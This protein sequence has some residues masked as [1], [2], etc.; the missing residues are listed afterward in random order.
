MSLLNLLQWLQSTGLAT[1][2][3]Q[4]ILVFPLVE[5]THILSLSVSV[6]MILVFDL[7]LMQATL[8]N[9]SVSLVMD[10][11]MRWAL[12]CFALTF[13]TGALLF[14]TEAVRAYEN[15]FFRA[16]VALLAMAGLNALFYRVRYVPQMAGWGD[17]GTPTGARVTGA[18]SLLFWLGVIACGRMVA[19]EL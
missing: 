6:G 5:G 7:R 4:S 14:C 1:S 10:S 8:R 2:L 18:L 17:A 9:Q 19:Y 3:K 16:K 11:I 13:C 12:P 15:D